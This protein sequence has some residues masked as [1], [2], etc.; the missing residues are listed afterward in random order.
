MKSSDL[1]Y[2]DIYIVSLQYPF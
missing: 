1:F 2:V